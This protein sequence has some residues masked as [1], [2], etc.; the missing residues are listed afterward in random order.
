MKKQFKRALLVFGS[1][2]AIFLG[3]IYANKSTRGTL[4]VF[5]AEDLRADAPLEDSSGG[6]GS[7]GTGGVGAGGSSS[8][9][10]GGGS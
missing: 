3:F 4:D 5:F 10:E 2:T 7:V 6:G 1:L 9:G 8:G